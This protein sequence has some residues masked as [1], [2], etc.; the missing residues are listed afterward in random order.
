MTRVAE[1]LNVGRRAMKDDTETFV[2]GK[3]VVPMT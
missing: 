2:F 3:W 1:K